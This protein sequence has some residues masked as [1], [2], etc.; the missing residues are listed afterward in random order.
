MQTLLV[1]IIIGASLSYLLWLGFK[2]FGRSKGKGGCNSCGK[3]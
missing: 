2:S 1:I 3:E